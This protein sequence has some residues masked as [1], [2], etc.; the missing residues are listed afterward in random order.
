[1]LKVSSGYVKPEY[2]FFYKLVRLGSCNI[3]DFECIGFSL[4]LK[5][6]QV[7]GKS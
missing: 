7:M 4:Y 1:M 3:A 6:V 2:A 5:F